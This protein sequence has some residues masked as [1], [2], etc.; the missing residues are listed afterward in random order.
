[1]PSAEE[2]A[3]DECLWVIFTD[4][5]PLARGLD[6]RLTAAGKRVLHVRLSNGSGGGDGIRL[7]PRERDDYHAVLDALAHLQPLRVRVI[8]LWE[9]GEPEWRDEPEAYALSQA[10]GYYSLVYLARALIAAQ[11]GAAHMTVICSGIHDAGCTVTTVPER[12]TLL[13]P[14]MVIPQEAPQITCRVVD[15]PLQLTLC[16]DEQVDIVLAEAWDTTG[17]KVVVYGQGPRLT[18]SYEGVVLDSAS[19]HQSRLK[20][21]GNYLVIGGL[22]PVGRHV[23]QY[24]ADRY[25][26]HLFLVGRTGLP[27]RSE[28]S[29]LLR[30]GD[31]ESETYRIIRTVT[32]LESKSEVVRVFQADVTQYGSIEAVVEEAEEGWGPLDGVIHC[33]S[34]S[35]DPSVNTPI[36]DLRESESETQFAAKV[37][38]LYNLARVLE[39]RSLD[40]CVVFSS[41]ASLLGGLGMTAYAAANCFADAFCT[42][43]RGRGLP[44]MS[45]NW[46]EWLLDEVG[47]D[48]EI[49]GGLHDYAMAPAESLEALERALSAEAI[50]QLVV[51]TADL[52]HRLG[53]WIAGTA[54]REPA[55][56]AAA[57]DGDGNI[58]ELD[59]DHGAQIPPRNAIEEALA[60]IWC[61]VLGVSS[62]GVRDNFFELGG[63]SLLA[64]HLRSKVKQRLGHDL[65][66]KAIFGA[67]TIEGMAAA[68][69]A[70]DRSSASFR[71]L[72]PLRATGDNPALYCVHPA[73][74]VARVYEPLSHYMGENQPFWALQARG[75][76]GQQ[77]PFSD[78]D[79]MVSTYLGELAVQCP[80]GPYFLAGWCAGGTIA[81]EMAQRLFRAGHQVHLALIDAEQPNEPTSTDDT[82]DLFAIA[83]THARNVGV[84]LPLR[85][86]DLASLST[87]EQLLHVL[88]QYKKCEV[89]PPDTTI[90]TMRSH[91]G[92]FL[93]TLRITRSYRFEPYGGTIALFLAE[94]LDYQRLADMEV[95]AG[96]QVSAEM[97]AEFR[98]RAKAWYDYSPHPIEVVTVPGYHSMMALEPNVRS[99]A[100]RLRAWIERSSKAGV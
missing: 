2:L 15:A 93:A 54:P 5:S 26:A 40:F 29:S 60:E 67:G 1:V 94:E 74:G 89:V 46:D 72:V 27:P 16:V 71:A 79:E 80:S 83:R 98:D 77:T 18:R 33:A 41:N 50:G 37:H 3:G 48:S 96:F 57:D 53:Q 78:M 86:D 85:R 44:W 9:S 6:K 62:V 81:Y 68:I 21:G 47:P 38:G 69:T 100:E 90:E 42:K 22:G 4:D 70:H 30:Q 59:E 31:G 66:L 32:Q 8:H 13:G 99:L 84:E 7:R 51:S 17:D 75:L 65:P 14:S 64:V 73:S 12:A 19:R 10:R 24:L 36:D 82:R 39:G 58:V 34:A 76:D 23:S 49:R 56:K 35:Q 28:W 55:G 88:R 20:H 61:E 25:G 91:W 63:H 11:C 97:L 92:V 43:M 87:D 52:S 45:V 95:T